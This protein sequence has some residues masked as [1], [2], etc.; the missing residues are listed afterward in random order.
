MGS[1]DKDIKVYEWAV[2]K[3][4]YSVDM[5]LHYCVFA[6]N[7]YGDLDTI[8]RYILPTGSLFSLGK[9]FSAVYQ[10]PHGFF[11]LLI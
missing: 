4:T 8:K 11:L 7:T 1:T 10:V 3:V 2:Q 5:W 9:L 6:I